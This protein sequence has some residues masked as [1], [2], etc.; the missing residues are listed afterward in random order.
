MRNNATSET[1]MCSILVSL[2]A[3]AGQEDPEEDKC[4][5]EG[6]KQKSF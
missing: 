6:Y 5:A 2:L 1:V 3:D 4:T